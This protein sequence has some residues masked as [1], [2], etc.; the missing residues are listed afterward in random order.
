MTF[1]RKFIEKMIQDGYV[2][3]ENGW[4]MLIREVN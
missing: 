1:M 2:L 3:D 4:L